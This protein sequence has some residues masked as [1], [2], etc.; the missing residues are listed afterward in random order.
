MKKALE[1]YL[2]PLPFVAIGLVVVGV[3]AAAILYMQRGQHIEV[4][5]A[6]LK[7]RTLGLED[8]S[9][10]AVMDFRMA[11]NADLPFLVR[12]VEPVL[13]DAKGQTLDGMAVAEIDAQRL[14]A[15]YPVLGQKFNDTLRIRTR[16]APHQSIDRML[17]ARFDTPLTA[18]EA[19]QALSI[20]VEDMGGAI[21][22]IAE[23]GKK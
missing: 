9:T 3:A 6:I 23:P 4:K 19:R 1:P 13:V 14:F 16:L 7:V 15:A 10:I 2:K 5:G 8:N 22:E 12:S 11:N 20:R 18:F 17:V 21:D